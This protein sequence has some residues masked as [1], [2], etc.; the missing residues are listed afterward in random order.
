[1]N[2]ADFDLVIAGGG[3]A[4]A[5]LA[6]AV[7]EAARVVVLESHAPDD[8]RQVSFD[9]RTI[10]LTHASQRVLEGIGA[11]SAVAADACPIH[12]I[13]V[14]D[15]GR[16]GAARLD[17]RD[18]GTEALGYVVPTRAL[19]SALT[20]RMQDLPG[21]ELVCPAT[22]EGLERVDGGIA[23]HAAGRRFQAPLLALADGGRSPLG[24]E[25]GLSLTARRYP[26]HALV[27]IVGVSREHRHLAYERFTEHGP[28]A[29]LPMT[30]RRMALAWT[31]PSETA[32]RLEHCDEDEFLAALQRGFGDRCGRFERVGA[33]RV[34]P[35]SRGHLAR[36]VA[37]RVVAV[38]NA[39]HIVHP[40]AGQGFNLGLRDVAELAERLL[41]AWAA[42]SDIGDAAL[43]DDYARS[44]TVQARR[45]ERFTDGLIGL[46]T[47]SAPGIGWL[48][49]AGLNLVDLLPPARRFLLARTMG[50]HGKL[51]ALV[52]GAR[53]R[54]P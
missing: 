28:L 41:A 1:M 27:A 20:A 25:A 45:V 40:V 2:E 35:L 12:A 22:A 8:A 29:L 33:R 39:A 3:L 31:L 51:P 16:F 50:R 52:R 32:A 48:R 46:T 26:Q 15:R 13:H 23:V 11:W 7:G 24:A 4:G 14:S 6:C 34:Y 36:P 43:L 5:S 9:E 37:G 21:V 49:S 44:R 17:R 53:P 10:A 19:G 18:A 54:R 30:G 42:G 47:S 38:G